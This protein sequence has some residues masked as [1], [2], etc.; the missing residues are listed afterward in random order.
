M[1]LYRVIRKN[2]LCLLSTNKF[3]DMN[4]PRNVIPPDTVKKLTE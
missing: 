1:E 2:P 4:Q 3:L